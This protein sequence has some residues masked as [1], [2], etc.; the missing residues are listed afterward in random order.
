M[1][2]HSVTITVSTISDFQKRDQFD[3]IKGIVGEVKMIG[4]DSSVLFCIPCLCSPKRSLTVPLV[5]PMY[6]EGRVVSFF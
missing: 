3:V 2:F 1:L 6:C 5:C 4:T